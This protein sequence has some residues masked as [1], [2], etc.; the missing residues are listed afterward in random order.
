MSTSLRLPLQAQDPNIPS[1]DTIVPV[2]PVPV[3]SELCLNA[4]NKSSDKVNE[5]SP[6]HFRY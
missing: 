3:K 6:G 1:E 4:L 2:K 5:L